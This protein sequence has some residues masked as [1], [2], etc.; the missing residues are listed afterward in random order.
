MSIQVLKNE[1]EFNQLVQ[2]NKDFYLLKHSLT[3][4]VS[5][6]VKTQFEKFNNKTEIPCYM[7]HVQEARPLSNKIAEG[8]GI[9]HESPQALLFHGKE[10]VW[11]DSHGAVTEE[12]LEES[13][14]K[15]S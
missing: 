13:T 3:C 7:L 10:V 6:F 2:E 5:T 8:Y 15:L 14:Q 4:P 9:R 11:H 1:E 12:A